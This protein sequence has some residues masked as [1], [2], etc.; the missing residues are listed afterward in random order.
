MQT[1]K[2]IRKRSSREMFGLPL[3]DIAIGPDPDS[4]ATQ[5]VLRLPSAATGRAFG[6][7]VQGSREDRER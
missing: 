6:D 2:T 3:F 5:H 1:T 4:V 7:G